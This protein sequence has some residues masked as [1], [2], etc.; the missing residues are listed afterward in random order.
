MLYWI[1]NNFFYLHRIILLHRNFAVV[2]I[3]CNIRQKPIKKVG[4]NSPGK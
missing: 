2:E 3:F 4:I 1:F